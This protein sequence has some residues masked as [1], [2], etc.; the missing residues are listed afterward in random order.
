MKLF[1]S[2]FQIGS[3]VVLCIQTSILIIYLHIHYWSISNQG[4][5][6]ASVVWW[7]RCTGS[8]WFPGPRGSCWVSFWQKTKYIVYVCSHKMVLVKVNMMIKHHIMGQP[9]QPIFRQTH[10]CVDHPN[11]H[12]IRKGRTI[13]SRTQ[14]LYTCRWWK[15]LDQSCSHYHQAISADYGGFRFVMGDPQ[16]SRS[17]M[18]ILALWGSPM[19]EPPHRE[20][21]FNPVAQGWQGSGAEGDSGRRIQSFK[22]V[23]VFKH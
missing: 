3:K 12:S 22:R 17:W 23:F 10:M 8:I 11:Y 16:S 5:L 21:P 18:T 1:A 15:R 6:V 14:I 19:N 2:S 20:V 7:I 4:R 9:G 13:K